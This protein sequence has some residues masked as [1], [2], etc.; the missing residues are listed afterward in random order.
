MGHPV[1]T[2]MPASSLLLCLSL[3]AVVNFAVKLTALG[4]K[5]E[6]S[7]LFRENHIILALATLSQYT[8][9]TDDRQTDDDGRYN[10]I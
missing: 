2:D 7:L 9:I 6:I 5:G 8:R 1:Y 3:K 4:L 10:Y